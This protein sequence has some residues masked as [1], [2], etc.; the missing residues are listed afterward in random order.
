MA[1][2]E[3]GKKPQQRRRRSRGGQYQRSLYQI[4]KAINS[5]RVSGEVPQALL[6]G[7]AEAMSAKGASLLLLNPERDQFLHI[8][9]HGVSET[10][11]RKGPLR[12][13]DMLVKLLA[14]EAVAVEDA[15][16][17]P[18]VQYP[19]E[20]KKEKIRSFLS[21][22]L[23]LW[24][25]VI[26]MLRVYTTRP[27]TYPPEAIEF[28]SAV[29]DLGAVALENAKAYEALQQE[30]D[31]TRQELLTWYAERRAAQ[32][33][34][35]KPVR[36]AHP[37]EEEFARLLDFYKIRWDYEPRS[38]PLVWVGDRIVEMFT[39]D[40]Y[41]I[42]HDQYIELT[43]LKQSL[44]T[45]KNRKLRHLRELHPEINIR[46]LYRRDYNKILAKYG[47]APLGEVG[48]ETP[49]RIVFTEAEIK[50]RVAAL[51]R[52]ITEDYAQS[53]PVL[54][55]VL[56]G[57]APFLNDLMRHINL[58]VE[59]DYLA[60][61]PFGG[62]VPGDVHFL[63]DAS[64][65]LRGRHVLLV[66][67][68][69]DTGMTLRYIIEHLHRREPTSLEVCVLLDKR[70][71]RLLESPLRYVGFE[72]P[73]EFLVGYGLDYHERY[74]NLPFIAIVNPAELAAP[75]GAKQAS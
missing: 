2:A 67:D 28:L 51:G 3:L 70:A 71:R 4:A 12:V 47:Y 64:L 49:G 75:V 68:I 59:V 23:R 38:F 45:R 13:D 50:D 10:F 65:D 27:R 9:A 44:T 69:I 22:P 14:G 11:L 46:L 54:I 24:D 29:A 39:P 41:L 52:T 17:D 25:E 56:K 48:A 21:V 6:R 36:F 32:E 74:R 42:D 60:I 63:L 34:P 15:Q 26:G 31:D 53:P 37:S 58:L 16:S 33:N 73:D 1:T 5:T 57:V 18:R 19:D 55:G 62:E 40:F 61:S 72:A 20:L 7:A 30:V 8:A 43:T 35:K 66:E